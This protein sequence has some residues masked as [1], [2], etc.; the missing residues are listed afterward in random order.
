M[1]KEIIK[2]KIFWISLSLFIFGVFLN[3][4]VS[5]FL[6]ETYKGSLPVLNDL[7]LDNIP[8]LK[9]MWL[10]DL[11]AIASVTIII[12][13]TYHKE[14]KKI[15]YFLLMFGL[16]QITRG[17]FIALT[18]FGSPNGGEIGLFNG[19]AFREGV[20][21][22]GHTANA[23]LTFILTEGVYKKIAIFVLLGTIVTLLL[24]RGHYSIDIFSAIFFTYAIFMFCEKYF[25]KKFVI[26]KQ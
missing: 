1:L 12:I 17:V 15:P 13:F 7:L 6:L 4:T 25:K 14:Q 18:P 20:Y 11:F 5:I 23:F 16:L 24:G 2:L 26:Q 21:P 10:Y 8:Y 19:S 9:I 3:Q 22:S